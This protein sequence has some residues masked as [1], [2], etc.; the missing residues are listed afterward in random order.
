[1]TLLYTSPRFLDHRTGEHP[2]NA[3][4]LEYVTAHLEATGLA[5]HCSKPEWQAADNATLS[6]VHDSKL[7]S[8]LEQLAEHGGMAD[9]D[10][11]VGHESVDVARLAAGAVVD[12]VNQ[13][14]EGQDP[15]ALCLVRPPGHHALRDTAM[16]FCLFNNIAVGAQAALNRD[17]NRILVIDWDVHHGNG[18]QAIFYQEPRVGFFSVHRWPFYPGTGTVDETGTGR[19]LGTTRNLPVIF[20]TSRRDYESM[21]MRELEDF[22][23]KIKPE[24][25]L[26]SAGF[27]AHH[28]DPVGS[29]GLEVEDF[30]WLTAAAVEI[31]NTYAEGRLVS[32]LEG[33]YNPPVLAECVAT[34]LE[35]LMKPR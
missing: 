2:E 34:H 14:I 12:A 3:Q 15:R 26:V 18:T 32:T 30:E 5:S 35:G 6:A 10:T 11:I 29:L 17:A 7:I 31:A 23:A 16:G 25:V 13:V 27:D 4:R 22:A 9:P 20:G 1:M 8:R 21:V 28:N 19:A 33:G 24:L